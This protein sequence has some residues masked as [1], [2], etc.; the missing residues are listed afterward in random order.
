MGAR[1]VLHPEQVKWERRRHRKNTLPQINHY[2]GEGIYPVAISSAW[3]VLDAITVP[4]PSLRDN[5][6]SKSLICVF[7]RSCWFTVVPTSNWTPNLVLCS[8]DQL[9]NPFQGLVYLFQSKE[10]A[11][12]LSLYGPYVGSRIYSTPAFHSQVLIINPPGTKRGYLKRK[13][14]Q[15]DA[16]S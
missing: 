16:K 6:C 15:S 13:P 2:L 7:S 8:V 1:T 10:V 4:S 9:W 3:C 11:I 5:K 12:L 14:W